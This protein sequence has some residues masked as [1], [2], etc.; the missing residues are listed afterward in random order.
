MDKKFLGLLGVLALIT[1]LA[2]GVGWL[3][4][5]RDDD[6]NTVYIIRTVEPANAIEGN[7]KFVECVKVIAAFS[8]DVFRSV[9]I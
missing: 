2:L 1:V 4:S 9:V 6:Q 3:N 7:A 5:S 8:S